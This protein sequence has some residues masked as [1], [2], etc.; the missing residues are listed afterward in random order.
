MRN[1]LILKNKAIF[2]DAFKK[3]QVTKIVPLWGSKNVYGM[4]ILFT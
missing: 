4:H 1:F 2:E 3:I